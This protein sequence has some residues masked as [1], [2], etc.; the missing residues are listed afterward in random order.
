MGCRTARGARRIWQHRRRYHSVSVLLIF[1]QDE[2]EQLLVDRLSDAGVLVERRTELVDFDQTADRI[3]ARLKLPDGRVEECEAAYVAGCD[4]A[5]SSVRETLSIGF[6][7]GTYSHLFY[8]ADV[9]ARG[10]AIDG[11]VHVALDRT[12]FLALFPMTGDHRVRLVGTIRDDVAHDRDDLSWNDVA[13]RVIEWMQIDVERVNWF[14]TYRV[15][16]A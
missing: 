2:H 5:H 11:D 8:V 7:G 6:P 13:Q 15:T 14:S 10:P 16:I 4:G 1:S 3:V 12:D 9:D